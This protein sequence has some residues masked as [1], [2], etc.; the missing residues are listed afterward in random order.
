MFVELLHGHHWTAGFKLNDIPSLELFSHDFT[1]VL[2]SVKLYAIVRQC[3]PVI[4]FASH[5]NLDYFPNSA[6]RRYSNRSHR[7][8]L[9]QRR[10]S[11]QARINPKS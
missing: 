7:S 8:S 1:L 10:T 3:S 5:R 4:K 6:S 9:S 2:V 11:R